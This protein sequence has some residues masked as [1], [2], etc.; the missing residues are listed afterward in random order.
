MLTPARMKSNSWPMLEPAPNPI[1]KSD[2]AR[3]QVEAVRAP[4]TVRARVIAPPMTIATPRWS[5]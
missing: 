5:R 4:V 3:S 2:G 1:R